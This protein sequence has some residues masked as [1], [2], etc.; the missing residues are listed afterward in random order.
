QIL[1]HRGGSVGSG[2]TAHGHPNQGS[3]SRVAAAGD[4]AMGG[5][6]AVSAPAQTVAHAAR[7]RTGSGGL[8]TGAAR[9]RDILR[10]GQSG[11]P[12][13]PEALRKGPVTSLFTPVYTV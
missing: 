2:G 8:E 1:P 10:Q 5:A 13:N 12:G 11:L 7:G 4:F 3:P 6:E 9:H